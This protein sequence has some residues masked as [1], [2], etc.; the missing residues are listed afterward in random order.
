MF[1]VLIH[2]KAV[3]SKY[4]SLLHEVIVLKYPMQIGLLTPICKAQEVL[5]LPKSKFISLL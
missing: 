3:E 2:C 4:S 1:R 5:V